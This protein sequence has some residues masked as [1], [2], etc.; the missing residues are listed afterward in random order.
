MKI[1]LW[2]KY[3]HYQKSERNNLWKIHIFSVYLNTG[4]TICEEKGCL[5]FSRLTVNMRYFKRWRTVLGRATAMHAVVNYQDFTGKQNKLF[6]QPLCYFLPSYA[7]G[8]CRQ[9]GWISFP[10]QCL[11]HSALLKDQ[12]HQPISS[13]NY[14]ANILVYLETWNWNG[15]LACSWFCR[16]YHRY[17]EKLQTYNLLEH[18]VV[19]PLGYKCFC[20]FHMQ[21]STLLQQFW[22]CWVYIFYES[23]VQSSTV[24]IMCYTLE[25]GAKIRCFFTRLETKQK[26]PQEMLK[27]LWMWKLLVW[28][29]SRSKLVFQSLSSHQLS[30]PHKTELN[31]TDF[32]VFFPTLSESA[33]VLLYV[34]IW[35]LV[36]T[37]ENLKEWILI[38]T[39]CHYHN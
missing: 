24:C 34:I 26:N 13:I 2:I 36:S 4:H 39:F 38:F 20:I 12:R 3:K 6:Q 28:S 30:H 23:L 27:G 35:S 14:W 9:G 18:F 7:L 29:L 15:L 1:L 16:Q 19:P 21:L 33:A 10:D 37:L 17:T 22:T 32:V 8:Q 31:L 25:W 5:F 11:M